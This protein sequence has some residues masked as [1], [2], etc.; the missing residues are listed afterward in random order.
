MNV[1]YH[2]RMY[3]NV[4]MRSFGRT[5]ILGTMIV[6]IISDICLYNIYDMENRIL[7]CH[8]TCII[9]RGLSHENGNLN[10]I[11]HLTD[12]FIMCLFFTGKM[13]FHGHE[14]RQILALAIHQQIY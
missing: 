2:T 4:H 12:I 14:T 3:A 10:F 8:L 5:R 9:C 11:C 13:A 7:A 1:A 6:S